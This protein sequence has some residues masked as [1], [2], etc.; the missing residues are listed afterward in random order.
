MKKYILSLFIVAFCFICHAQNYDTLKVY[1]GTDIQSF[2]ISNIDSITHK[3]GLFVNIFINNQ[4]F[5]Y[6]I[7]NVDSILIKK[8]TG[9]CYQIPKEQ[10]NGWD[11][12]VFYTDIS[13]EANSF[14]IVSHSDPEDGIRTVYLN[15]FTN[16]DYTQ[17]MALVFNSTKEIHDI[18]LAGYQFEAY[19]REECVTFVAY[20]KDGK[21]IDSFDV[22]YEDES[23]INARAK[24][25]TR[26][27]EHYRLVNI[28]SF[29]GKAG[30]VIWNVADIGIKLEEGKY[31]DILK[32]YLI[33]KLVGQVTNSFWVELFL[34]KKIDSF[35]KQL[36]E[37][38]KNW[39]MGNTDISITSIKRVGK[40]A[41]NVEGEINNISTIPSTRLVASESPNY[42]DNKLV[43]LR[44]VPNF[45][46]YGVAEGDSG[47][48]G[49]YL[50]DACTTPAI[51]SGNHFSC[52]LPVEHNPGKTYYFRPFL[53]PAVSF[54]ENADL[55]QA[56]GNMISTNIRYGDRKEFTDPKPT[57]STG[58]V[59][60][61]STKSAVVNC[62]FYGAEGFEC[63]VM[64][65][66]DNET[67]YIQTSCEDGERSI[68]IADLSPSTTYLYCAYI[69]IDEEPIHGELYAFTTDKEPDPIA[70]TGECSETSK[71][72]ATVSCTYENVPEG[73]VCGVEYTWKDGSAKQAVSS[74]NGTQSITLSDLQPGT[75]YTYCA[76]IEANGKTYYGEDKSFTTEY[77]DISGTWNGATFESESDAV[78]DN[79]TITLKSDG[80]GSAIKGEEKYDNISWGFRGKKRVEIFIY[81]WSSPYSDAYRYLYFEGDMND[82]LNP[83]KLEGSMVSVAGN[84]YGEFPNGLRCVLTK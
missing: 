5:T 73:G 84:Q 82:L 48:P 10:L 14:Y 58:K 63:G 65:K 38:N 52:T 39:F 35:L 78:V 68:S 55:G 17:S 1:Q 46:L 53:I 67:K 33:G 83:T 51:V 42:I 23:D 57:C 66:S 69:D 60:S 40:S 9:V 64:V 41:I 56:L 24:T 2:P 70:S 26:A 18:F 19:P 81:S 31:A 28:R 30:K 11:D 4:P 72:S 75:S 16:D 13:N 77:P 50:H 37:N 25:S 61:K 12:G 74:S 54:E 20:D 8:D 22:P 44:E 80:T 49:L 71:T 45:V 32:D 3:E 43:Y 79:W 62:T 29:L 59:V 7:N 76:Y 15:N 21:A 47:Q 6:S 27:I 36:Y 34:A